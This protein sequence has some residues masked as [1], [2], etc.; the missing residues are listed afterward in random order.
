MEGSAEGWTLGPDDDIEVGA[1]DGTPDG[2]VLGLIEG[3]G[4]FV[5]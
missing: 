2:F 3:A 5:G 1:T 4:E